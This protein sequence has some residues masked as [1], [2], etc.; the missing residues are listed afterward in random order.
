MDRGLALAVVAGEVA[1][2]DGGG[3]ASAAGGAGWPAVEVI[4]ASTV[5]SG[6]RP[7]DAGILRVAGDFDHGA[8]G[9][10]H[11]VEA[12]QA[13]R[14]SGTIG[15]MAVRASRTG[16]FRVAADVAAAGLICGL[17]TIPVGLLTRFGE[18]RASGPC[19]AR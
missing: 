6:G 19:S 18:P 5:P 17:A 14:G 2:D 7:A 11:P 13:R 3:C 1:G 16:R 12:W 4:I 9:W 15:G 8:C 10:P